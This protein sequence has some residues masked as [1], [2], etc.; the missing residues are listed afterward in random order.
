MKLTNLVAAALALTAA[1]TAA[2]GPT[3]PLG[4]PLGRTLGVGL[5]SLLGTQLGGVALPIVGGGLLAV[6]AASLA[7]GI[8]IVRRKKNR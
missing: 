8:W 2:A 4:T 5:G 3:V 7:F 1:T 6:A